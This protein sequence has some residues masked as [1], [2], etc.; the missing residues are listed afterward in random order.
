MRLSAASLP[1]YTRESTHATV[2]RNPRAGCDVRKSYLAG[3][4]DE[5]GLAKFPDQE[6]E[7][8]RALWA[9]VEALRKKAMGDAGH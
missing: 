4:R 5:A 6:R 2:D 8:L 1:L 3:I 7:A 9:D